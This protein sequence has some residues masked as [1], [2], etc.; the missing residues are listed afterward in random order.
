PDSLLQEAVRALGEVGGDDVGEKLLRAWK[1]LTASSR[2][3]VAE[4]LASRRRWALS[5]LAMVEHEMISASEVPIP[6]RRTLTQSKDDYVRNRATQALG[7]YRETGADKL[8]LIA[9]KKKIV[10]GGQAD[11]EKG[12]EVAKRTCLTCHKLHGEGADVGP[13]LTGV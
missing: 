12:H 13:D 6:V 2:R 10:L 11:L 5:F 4:A 3:T 9:E 8:K 7:R 1:S